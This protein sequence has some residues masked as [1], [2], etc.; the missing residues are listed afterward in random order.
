MPV[1]GIELGFPAHQWDLLPMRQ[2]LKKY[3][4]NSRMYEQIFAIGTLRLKFY[5]RIF[6]F[7]S[8]MIT[9]DVSFSKING[10]EFAILIFYENHVFCIA[11]ST[12]FLNPHFL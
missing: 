10:S 9:N 12:L 11:K 5:D 2:L 7:Y 1:A 3:S 8:P 4:I 6:F